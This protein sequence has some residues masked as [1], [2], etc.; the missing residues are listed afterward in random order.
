MT[1]PGGD[2]EVDLKPL[3]R[4]LVLGAP[5]VLVLEVDARV[6]LAALV[7]PLVGV[8]GAGRDLPIL[9]LARDHTQRRRRRAH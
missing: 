5:A 2:P 8:R 6:L 1:Y 9:D 3:G 4:G 7:V